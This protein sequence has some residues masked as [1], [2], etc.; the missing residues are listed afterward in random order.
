MRVGARAFS[1]RDPDEDADDVLCLARTR[2][3]AK[4]SDA[5][6]TAHSRSYPPLVLDL[7]RLAFDSVGALFRPRAALLA[8]N[9]ALR[10]QLGILLRSRPARL[11]L[12]SWDRAL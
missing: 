7:V 12:T 8:E 3:L 5:R 11:P 1:L 6:M 10:H 4:G 2:K 9:L